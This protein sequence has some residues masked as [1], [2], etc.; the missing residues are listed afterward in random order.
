MSK[1]R[2][3]SHLQLGRSGTSDSFAKMLINL[4]ELV[5]NAV[6]IEVHADKY[7]GTRREDPDLKRV[8]VLASAFLDNGK[9]VP[10]QFE[11]KE[12]E[13]KDNKL[14]VAV[15]MKQNEAADLD[16]DTPYGAAGTTTALELSIPELV[17]KINPQDGDFLKYIPDSM[18]SNEQKQS[19][20]AALEKEQA[21]IVSLRNETSSSKKNEKV[22]GTVS[23]NDHGSVPGRLR[24]RQDR[25]AC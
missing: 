9:I 17:Q 20:A 2:E 3:S 8:Y 12:F 6:P 22:S 16:A 13:T 7:V 1:F 11:V 18:L 21:K 19:K 14:Y 25:R 5:T 10:V 23:G 24:R 4:D 15:S